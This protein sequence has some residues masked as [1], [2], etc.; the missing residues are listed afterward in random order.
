MGNCWTDGA[1][2]SLG[3]TLKDLRVFLLKKL[4]SKAVLL[5]LRNEQKQKQHKEISHKMYA[6]KPAYQQAFFGSL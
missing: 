3:L 4:S 2:C 6:K 5:L 1:R